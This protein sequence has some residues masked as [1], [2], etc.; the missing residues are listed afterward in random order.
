M[1]CIKVVQCFCFLVAHFWDSVNSIC[2]ILLM[3]NFRSRK[4]FLCYNMQCCSNA[5][6]LSLT[7]VDS[8]GSL[9]DLC[10]SL[11]FILCCPEAWVYPHLPSFVILFHLPLTLLP[12]LPHFPPPFAPYN[13]VPELPLKT[14]EL[15]RNCWQLVYWMARQET[16]Y[17]VRVKSVQGRTLRIIKTMRHFSTVLNII[18]AWVMRSVS[19]EPCNSKI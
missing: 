2:D 6:S 14:S 8:K 3:E 18:Y 4:S 1:Y 17:G 12:L 13:V 9:R 11:P 5:M 7:Q 15:V 10:C 19:N 16:I